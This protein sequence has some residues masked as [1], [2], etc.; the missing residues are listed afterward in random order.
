MVP[1]STGNDAKV[2]P[3]F[4]QVLLNPKKTQEHMDFT[5]AE[6]KELA[7]GR[8]RMDA[9]LNQVIQEAEE[10]VEE[11]DGEEA[12]DDGEES[13]ETDQEEWENL[14]CADQEGSEVLYLSKGF[15]P[16]MAGKGWRY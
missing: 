16:T 10:E 7:L 1:V 3:Q 5:D 14:N 4:P 13:E 12:I 9:L 6:Y 11:W 15:I 2:Q 8:G